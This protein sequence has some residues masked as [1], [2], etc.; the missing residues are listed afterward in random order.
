MKMSC[1]CVFARNIKNSIS[2]IRLYILPTLFLVQIL[3][4]FSALASLTTAVSIDNSG[5]ILSAPNPSENL[6]IIPDSFMWDINSAASSYA[7]VDYSVTHNGHS[8]IR[9]EADYVRGT[10][11]INC[12]YP[13][14]HPGDH[15]VWKVWCKTSNDVMDTQYTGGRIGIDLQGDYGEAIQTVDSLPRDISYFDGAYRSSNWDCFHYT[16]VYPEG[17]VYPYLGTPAISQFKVPFSTTTWTLIYWDFIVPST[18][19]YFRD[20][21]PPTQITHISPWLDA[22]E[23]TDGTIWFADSEFYINP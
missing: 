14:V 1:I 15:I 20:G 23:L 11:E 5:T 19:Y 17:D 9:L 21:H 2:K 18:T 6:V 13:E 12:I 22:R 8:S 16:Y 3:F 7:Y 4:S 10:R